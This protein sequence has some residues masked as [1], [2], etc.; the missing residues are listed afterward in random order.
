MQLGVWFAGIMINGLAISVLMAI[1]L[2]AIVKLLRSKDTISIIRSGA[3]FGIIICNLLSHLAT[4]SLYLQMDLYQRDI[5]NYESFWPLIMVI[6]YAFILLFLSVIVWNESYKMNRNGVILLVVQVI[7]SSISI[8]YSTDYM[9]FWDNGAVTIMM[10][11]VGELMFLFLGIFVGSVLIYHAFISLEES[12]DDPESNRSSVSLSKYY[13]LLSLSFFMQF[14]VPRAVMGSLLD[15]FSVKF[16]GL[17]VS[18]AFSLSVIK[19]GTHQSTIESMQIITDKTERVV[20]KT[21]S[22]S[23]LGTSTLIAILFYFITFFQPEID[24]SW[25]DFL[26]SQSLYI[27]TVMSTMIYINYFSVGIPLIC[28]IASMLFVL[29]QRINHENTTIYPSGYLLVLGSIISLGLIIASSFSYSTGGWQ[30]SAI[31]GH[32]V[33]PFMLSFVLAAILLEIKVEAAHAW[34]ISNSSSFKSNSIRIISLYCVAVISIL[35][36]DLI[37]S[38]PPFQPIANQVFIGAA[39]IFDGVF[40]APIMAVVVFEVTRSIRRMI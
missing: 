30:T 24:A 25:T 8:I 15:P 31:R 34:N 32:F 2:F 7:I 40:W 21:P 17:I 13:L 23:L 26:V 14:L 18:M 6:S 35:I 37:T 5:G 38:F 20:M 36:A 16:I 19:F 33:I 29:Y 1:L 4:L 10:P 12:I 22:L 28:L 27:G 39:G 9:V 11:I 3:C